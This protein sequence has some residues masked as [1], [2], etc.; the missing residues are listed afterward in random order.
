MILHSAEDFF[1]GIN[2]SVYETLKDDYD[3]KY[4]YI[5]PEITVDKNIFS[6][7][8]LG[9]L[10]L[11]TNFKV[12]NYD[13]NKFASFFVNDLDWESNDLTFKSVIKNKFLGKFKNI[14]YEARNSDIYKDEITNEFYGAIGLQSEIDFQR[15]NNTSHFLHL[16]YY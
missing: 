8:N 9:S 7:E 6:D 14:N 12:H 10:D 5:L 4:E 16:N 2:A 1:F 11:Q 3:D 15:K 13:T